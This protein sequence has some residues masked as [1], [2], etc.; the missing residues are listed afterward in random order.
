MGNKV[1][2]RSH[3]LGINMQTNSDDLLLS[4]AMYMSVYI[5]LVNII[6]ATIGALFP[7]LIWCEC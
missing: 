2:E 5:Y 1:T 7:A 3:F 4:L 6:G